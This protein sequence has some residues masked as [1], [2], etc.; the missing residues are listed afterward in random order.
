M[1]LV[2]ILRLFAYWGTVVCGLW[3]MAYLYAYGTEK[4]REWYRD[5]SDAVGF[6][7]GKISDTTRWLASLDDA[8]PLHD[9]I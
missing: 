9:L 5:V 4:G 7:R 3:T 6:N 8:H 1:K 2:V